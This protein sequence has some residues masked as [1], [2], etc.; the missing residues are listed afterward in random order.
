MQVGRSLWR[1]QRQRLQL[2]K[3]NRLL[4]DKLTSRDPSE[5]SEI[6][7]DASSLEANTTILAPFEGLAM[8]RIKF[9]ALSLRV[10]GTTIRR[11]FPHLFPKPV[12]R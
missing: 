4:P 5:L 3:M 8:S 12:S 7:V 6:A 10:S 11:R 9:T 2:E 1:N